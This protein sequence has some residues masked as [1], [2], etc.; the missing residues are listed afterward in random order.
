MISNDINAILCSLNYFNIV[1]FAKYIVARYLL[2]F[3]KFQHL[4]PVPMAMKVP[5]VPPP[6]TIAL[7]TLFTSSLPLIPYLRAPN[8][9]KRAP[10]A[11]PTQ[12]PIMK[13]V[14][15]LSKQL[16]PWPYPPTGTGM[17]YD[18]FVRCGFR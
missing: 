6:W 2:D 7:P 1:L 8:P 4:I 18:R 12:N 13:P 3:S 16:G 15:I 9:P 14:F 11:I 10:D 17:F 5:N